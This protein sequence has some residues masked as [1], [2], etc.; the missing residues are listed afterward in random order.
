MAVRSRDFEMILHV[1][2]GFILLFLRL[3]ARRSYCA[4]NGHANRVGA[5]ASSLN[6]MALSLFIFVNEPRDL[7]ELRLRK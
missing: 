6:V 5:S 3:G 7:I 1:R 2:A 4:S